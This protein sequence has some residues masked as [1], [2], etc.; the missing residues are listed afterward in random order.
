VSWT[1]GGDPVRPYRPYKEG[2]DDLRGKKR[3][4]P[5]REGRPIFWP[6][7]S[8][9]IDGRHVGESSRKKKKRG[10]IENICLPREKKESP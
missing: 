9:T 2:G 6:S 5:E 7:R 8:A 3:E 1:D 4:R 10:K